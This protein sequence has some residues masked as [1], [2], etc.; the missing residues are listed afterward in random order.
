MK[1]VN[2]YFLFSVLFFTLFSC[3]KDNNE[4]TTNGYDKG[5]YIVNEGTMTQNNGSIS[6][7]NADSNKVT[8]NL[9]FK[10]NG[11]NLGDVLQSFEVIENKGFAVLNN[12]GKIEVFEMK[13]FKST[14]VITGFSYPRFIVKHSS[15]SAYVSNGNFAGMVYVINP[16]TLAKIDSIAVGKGPECMVLI[17]NKLY[18]ANSGGWNSDSTISVIDCTTNTLTKTIVVDKAPN[19]M[20]IDEGNNLWV[21]CKNSLV[22]I[23]TTSQT[24]DKS[25]G[26]ANE[27]TFFNPHRLA[28]SKDK[29][30]IYFAH[31]GGIF[32]IPVASTEFPASVFIAGDFYGVDVN[33]TNDEIYC[34]TAPFTGFGDL[35]RFSA[36]G[37]LLKTTTVENFPAS[38]V[39]N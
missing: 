9:F 34:L 16:Q 15:T 14:G 2:I 31:I 39:F 6:Y 13:T 10:V 11:R 29:K 32:A 26:F 35:K 36:A 18:V 12:S 37:I 4:T 7:Y 21:I 23:N 17:N 1:K 30:I 24:V 38:V 3:E 27:G 19:D 28:I 20:V 22:K 8:E 33:P 25:I 5:I